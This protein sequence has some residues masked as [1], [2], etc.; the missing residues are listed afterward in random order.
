M[1]LIKPKKMCSPFLDV[2]VDKSGVL[3]ATGSGGDSNN[4]KKSEK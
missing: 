2:H 3:R 1:L 4:R